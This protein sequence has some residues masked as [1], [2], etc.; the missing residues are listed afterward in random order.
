[1]TPLACTVMAME[2]FGAS[3]G[4]W[5]AIACVAAMLSSGRGGIY[6]AQKW[7]AG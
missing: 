7:A 4:P 2:L 6:S 5:A 3:T 1:N